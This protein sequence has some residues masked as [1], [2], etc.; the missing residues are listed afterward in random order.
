MSGIIQSKFVGWFKLFFL[1]EKIMGRLGAAGVVLFF[2]VLSEAPAFAL[3]CP[4]PSL[5]LCDKGICHCYP[6]TTRPAFDGSTI[7][8]LQ[9]APD[10]VPNVYKRLNINPGNQIK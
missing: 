4:A 1:G 6:V 9:V 10:Q 2:L 5:K 8:E 7:I 3:T